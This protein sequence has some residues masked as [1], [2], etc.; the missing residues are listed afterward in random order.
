M[1]VKSCYEEPIEVKFP[2]HYDKLSSVCDRGGIVTLCELY[3]EI[4]IL[5]H[6]IPAILFSHY[7]LGVK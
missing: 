2:L 1:D 6:F 5:M 4:I 3:T 7:L